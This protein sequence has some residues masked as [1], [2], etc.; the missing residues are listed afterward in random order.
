MEVRELFLVQ[1]I[2]MAIE[3]RLEE[4]HIRFRGSSHV[5]VSLMRS[6]F[7]VNEQRLEISSM[8]GSCI[9]LPPPIPG[10]FRFPFSLLCFQPSFQ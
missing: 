7:E 6:A 9:F 8:G 3:R 2:C 10:D 4:K 1:R 5:S